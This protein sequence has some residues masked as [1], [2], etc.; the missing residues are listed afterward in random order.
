MTRLKRGLNSC[1][2]RLN[3]FIS[4]SPFKTHCLYEVQHIA[5]GKKIFS[6]VCTKPLS[7]DSSQNID[8]SH[9]IGRISQ[10]PSKLS[11][12]PGVLLDSTFYLCLFVISRFFTNFHATN[13]G[14]HT[15]VSIFPVT[16]LPVVVLLFPHPRSLAKFVS[17]QLL[18]RCRIS[19][20]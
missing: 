7:G 5:A 15:N 4:C 8:H 17:R 9:F 3:V 12:L 10:L 14:R 2:C 19:S 6:I 1:D 11:H 18:L 13:N 16:I 20:P